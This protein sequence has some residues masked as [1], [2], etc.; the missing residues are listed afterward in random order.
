LTPVFSTQHILFHNI[1]AKSLSV[2]KFGCDLFERGTSP[3]ISYDILLLRRILAAV[4]H[5]STSSIGAVL[6]KIV[7]IAYSVWQQNFATSEI[8]NNNFQTFSLYLQISD[9]P[10]KVQLF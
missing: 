8:K 2:N 5:S 6:R 7:S 9:M 4:N 3:Q 10:W 1:S